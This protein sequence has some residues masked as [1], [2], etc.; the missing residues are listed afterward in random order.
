M[1]PVPGLDPRLK[2]ASPVPINRRRPG[3]G[4][5]EAENH[6]QFKWVN[7]VNPGTMFKKVNWSLAVFCLFQEVNVVRFAAGT[8]IADEESSS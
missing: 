4:S 3:P 8:I 2:G 1:P 7:Y 5:Q 6:M